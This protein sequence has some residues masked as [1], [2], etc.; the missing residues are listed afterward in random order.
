MCWLTCAAFIVLTVQSISLAGIDLY[1]SPDGRDSW[2]GKL[3]APD[4]DGTD[5]PLAT[6]IAARDRIR[7]L[8]KDADGELPPVVTV[9]LRQGDYILD[10]P[11]KLTEADANSSASPVI[12]RAY[13][14]ERVRLLGG[15]K[16]TGFVPVSNPD[17]LDRL[18]KEARGKVMVADLKTFGIED[19]GKAIQANQRLELFFD[20]KPMQLARWPN[21][22][23]VTIKDVV[24]GQPK[25]IHGLTGDAI[26]KFTYS[27]DRP[28]RWR[29]ENDLYVHGY[30]FWDWADAYQPVAAI[31][32]EK[33]V[34]ELAKPYHHY[35]YRAGQRWYAINAFAEIDMPGEWYL[36][37]ESGMLYFW[38]PDGR[39]DAEVFLSMLPEILTVDGASN[40]IFS[41]LT[42]C[43]SRSTAVAIKN[44]DDVYIEGC[45]IRN[46]GGKAVTVNGGHTCVVDGCDIFDTGDG[47]ILMVGGNR[48]E[49]EPAFHMA[50]NNHIYRYSRNSNTYRTAVTVRGVGSRIEHN[51]IHDAPHMAIYLHGNDHTVQYNEIHHVCMETDDAGAFYMGRD[52]TCRSN[53]VRYN[54]FHHI[55]RLKTHVGTQAI[56]LDDWTS[57][58]TVEGNICYKVYRAVLVGGGRDNEIQRNVLV[59]CN[60]GIHVDSRGL[61]WAKYYFNGENNTLVKRLEAVNYREPPWSERYPELLTL[62][63]DEPALAKYNILEHNILYDCE[64]P[65]DLRDGLTDDV[66]TMRSN[67]IGQDP[68]F[69]ASALNQ[70]EDFMLQPDSPALEQGFEPLPLKKIG[71]YEDPCRATWPAEVR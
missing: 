32:P 46:V 44:A 57:D 5:G 42:F 37:R 54:Y 68:R 15:R 51:L 61:G 53:K 25:K 19:F 20:D 12:Y 23:Y 33:H 3:A 22:G 18:P 40:T 34:I 48:Q 58:T 11:V 38:P 13:K 31:D 70:P 30:W 63:E 8:R 39:A 9:H 36:D 21:E 29:E 16:I 6:L 49:F 45:V 67:L 65:I 64:K 14:D 62:Y 2:S 55:G 10:E 7:E 56:Y 28:A 27:G 1:V 69:K 71:L 47:G 60:I 52:W 24:G 17:L 66:V 4:A 35:G 26:G 59:D 41:R 50:E 43:F